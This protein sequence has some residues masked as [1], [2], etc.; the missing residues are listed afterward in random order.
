MSDSPLKTPVQFL[1]GVGPRRAAL[2][3]KL[4]LQI[5]EDILWFVPRD[6]LDLTHVVSPA[7]LTADTVHTVK[8]KVTDLEGRK[9][10]GGR[11]MSTVL[12]DCGEGYVRAS[13][14]NQ[15][16][17]LQRA[18]PGDVALLSGKCKKRMGRWEFSHPRLQWLEEDL[19]DSSGGI[20]PKYRL[21]EGLAM[22][23]MRRIARQVATD[24]AD[25]V[26]DPLPPDFCDALKLPRIGAALNGLHV[27]QTLA[28]FEAGRLRLVFDDL[29]EFQVGVALRRRMW[30]KRSKAPP[31]NVS[32]KVDLRIRKL[33]PFEFTGGQN[34]AVHDITQDLAR[35]HAMHRLLQADVG[36]G[37]TV[38]AVYAMLAAVAAGYQTVLMA[39]T[40]LLARQHWAT[41]DAMLKLSRVNRTYLSGSLR[42]LERA[43][44]RQELETGAVQLVVGTHAVISEGVK[45]R[46][47]GVVVIDEQH[48]F[49]VM[50]RGRFASEGTMPH[51]LVMT[52]TPIPRS[53]CLTQ[54]GDLDLT[55]M[56]DLPPGRQPVVTSRVPSGP[57][58]AKVWTFVRAKLEAGRQAYVVC[59]RISAEVRNSTS[60]DTRDSTVVNSSP[61]QDSVAAASD[62]T[63]ASGSDEAGDRRAVETV[64][65]ELRTGDLKGYRLAMLHGGL[66]TEEKELAM[67]RFRAREIDV[68]VATT[69]VEVGVDVP[70][71][72]LM[73]IEQ[74][75]SFGLSQLHQLRGRVGRG[76]F[77]GYCFLMSTSA[78][79]AAAQRLAV[80]EAKSSGFDVAEADFALRGPG[81]VLGTRQSGL[82]P[83]RVADLARDAT[84][85]A[86]TRAAA[87]EL[88]QSSQ[89]DSPE[90][91]PLKLRVIERFGQLFEITGGG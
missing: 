50:Q 16:W 36:A 83:L 14:F 24:Y 67:R 9:L 86:D 71:A 69:M 56:T 60:V 89:I 39:P 33:F 42:P 20:L 38:I 77:Q 73:V 78:D 51:T 7:D 23:E 44:V 45:F 25:L 55:L 76:Q 1:P 31:I 10:S 2:L 85:V 65:E 84:V 58:R 72:T 74:A 68:L 63:E 34:R 57:A 47:L 91:A 49:G 8:G 70:N 37:K 88:V 5:A 17:V 66:S 64:F 80:L 90:F 40:E 75:E 79:E 46:N 48:R 26:P 30:R 61:E 62:A 53:L 18:R 11:T 87:F 27:P 35:P 22:H 52:A 19:G 12:F 13:W 28:E 41:I 15:P 81:D 3:E 43:R 21:T 4:D 29:L 6:V 82:L 32:T 59:P 54:F